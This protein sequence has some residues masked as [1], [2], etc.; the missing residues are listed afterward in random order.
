L[1]RARQ[2]AAKTNMLNS[3]KAIQLEGMIT[4]VLPGTMFRVALAN[5]HLVLAH[6]SGKM[7]KR[8]I[9]LTIGDRVKMEMSPYDAT[10]AR[11]VYRL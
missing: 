9:R 8:F 11:I 6:V 4:A 10:K 5:D 3:E 1:V 7:R 2:S